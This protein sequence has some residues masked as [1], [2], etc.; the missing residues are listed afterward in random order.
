[1]Y[2]Y[3]FS[4][5][6]ALIL[7]LVFT[8]PLFSQEGDEIPENVIENQKCFHCHGDRFYAYY[9]DYVERDVRERMNPYF[10]IDSAQFYQSNHKTFL[11]TDCHSSDYE[12]FP[13]DG[14]LRMEPKFS[15]LDCHGG[16]ETYAEFQFEKIEEEFQQ[17][18]HSTL[19]SD[20]FTCWMCHNPHTYKVNARNNKNI[21]D[22]I[23]Y[24]NS[25]CLSCHADI[26]KYQLISKLTNPN[27]LA[28]HEWLPN[29]ALHFSKVRCIECHT[30]V[31]KDIL[32]AHKVMPK[33]NAVRKCVQCHSQ[34][35]LLMAT[36]Y[37]FESFEKRDNL[38]FFNATMLGEHYIIGANRNYYLNVASLLIFG[39]VLM[40]IIIHSVLRFI[41]K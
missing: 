10:V 1:M 4:I 7:S 22:L 37:K 20:D 28:T 11:C 8:Q 38:G 5:A 31:D 9:N 12:N 26:D 39:F 15:C 41:T 36:L 24:D 33:E 35:S 30:E 40:G 25:I 21:H 27:V 2:K 3:L 29:Q 34:N 17:S 18:V 16:D 14:L 23:V 6:I 19:H 13:H 32:I